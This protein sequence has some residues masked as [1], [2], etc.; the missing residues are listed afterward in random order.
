VA[1]RQDLGEHGIFRLERFAMAIFEHHGRRYWVVS[2]GLSNISDRGLSP[3]ERLVAWY[4]S[5]GL[6]NAMIAH[7]RHVSVRTVANQVAS[8]LSKLAVSSRSDIGQALFEGH[9]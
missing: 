2:A 9:R 1:D 5:Q 6:S 7:R 3:T 4:V 8:I